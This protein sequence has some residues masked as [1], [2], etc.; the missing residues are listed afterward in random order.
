MQVDTET[1]AI[2]HKIA[3]QLAPKFRFG[4][5]DISDIEQE[6]IILGLDA[7]KRWDQIRPLEN[8]IYTHIR[9]RLGTLK[10][11]KYYRI[12]GDQP[13]QIQE[14]KKKLLDAADITNYALPAASS[15]PITHEIFALIDEKL[16]A[17]YRGDYLRY[18]DGVKLNGGRKA[19]IIRL[20]KTILE[21]YHE[22]N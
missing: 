18:R 11:D 16:P 10:R 22:E 17:A 8:F 4:Y 1:L 7:V 21:D 6:A 5:Y 15:P 2:I 19:N 14:D 9:N 20:L 12:D 3:K 13:S